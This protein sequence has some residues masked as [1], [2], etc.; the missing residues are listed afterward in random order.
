MFR[1]LF[2]F[3][4]WLSLGVG[5][6]LAESPERPP[7][8][9]DLLAGVPVLSPESEGIEQFSLTLESPFQEKGLVRCAF[10]WQRNEPMQLY[11]SADPQQLPIWLAADHQLMMFDLENQQVVLVRDTQPSLTL[12][13]TTRAWQCRFGVEDRQESVT[14]ADVSIDLPSFFSSESGDPKIEEDDHGN[15]RY[16]SLSL[17]GKSK[18][19]ATFDRESPYSV[20]DIK[21]ENVESGKT[22][23]RVHDICVNE[24]CTQPWLRFPP[25]D[26]LPEQLDVLTIPERNFNTGFQIALRWKRMVQLILI[27]QMAASNKSLRLPPLNFSELEWQAMEQTKQHFGPRL[28]YLIGLRESVE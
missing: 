23:L 14:Q 25:I 7:R 3:A 19:S 1:I 21:I 26:T 12:K 16:E 22:L 4:A 24:E 17:S 27:T 6:L 2:M 18:L 11:L 28:R 5:S 10:R 8:L 9:E 15:W 13:V 20:R